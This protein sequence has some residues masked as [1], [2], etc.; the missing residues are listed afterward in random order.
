M[1]S[2]EF[3]DLKRYVGFDDDDVRNLLAVREQ[4]QPLIPGAVTAF[5]DVI[6]QHTGARGVLTDGDSHVRHLSGL[7]TEWI[8]GLFEGAYDESYYQARSRIGATHVRVGL[9]QKYMPLAMHVVWRELS[10][11]IRRTIPGAYEAVLRS[12]HKL[13]FLDLTIMLESYKDSYS[14]RM[15]AMERSGMEARLAKVEHLAEIGQLAASLA[16]EIKNP[17]AG[18]S[19]AIQVIGE[20]L[21]AQSPFKSIIKDILHQISRLDATVKD[22][23]LYARPPPARPASTSLRKLVPRTLTL[24]RKEP[25]MRNLRV[26]FVHEDLDTKVYADAGQVEQLLINLVLNAADACRHG[27]MIR[28]EVTE[29]GEHTLLIVRDWGAGMSPEV[30]QRAM[31]PFYTTKAKGTGLGLAICRRIVESNG[32]ALDIS[33]KVDEGTT[34]TASLPRTVDIVEED[35]TGSVSVVQDVKDGEDDR[36]RS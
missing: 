25:S 7:L 20:S 18:I 22:L 27:D 19:G 14:Q 21:D 33:S 10:E 32:G 15:R 23:L 2:A 36:R 34:V 6:L 31:E 16:H 29:L 4:V 17:L 1:P 30:C 28:V 3:E 26:E 8:R 13:L 11:G 9:P 12:L 5:Y 24:L 35:S